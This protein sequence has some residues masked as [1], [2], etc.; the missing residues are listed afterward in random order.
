MPTKT[1]GA[2]G[3][4]YPMNRSTRSQSS[5]TRLRALS[6]KRRQV[7][8]SAESGIHARAPVDD[9]TTTK[10]LEARSRARRM[11]DPTKEERQ[12]S[13]VRKTSKRRAG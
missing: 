12:R 3:L 2:S 9:R 7:G 6:G 4:P 5:I 8:T 11:R 13:M 1:I 10:S